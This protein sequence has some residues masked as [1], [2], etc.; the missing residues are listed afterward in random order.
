LRQL[1]ALEE[2]QHDAS[3]AIGGHRTYEP[4]AFRNQVKGHAK[5][6]DS[7]LP[8]AAFCQRTTP[9]LQQSDSAGR[10]QPVRETNVVGTCADREDLCHASQTFEVSRCVRLGC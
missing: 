3:P 2:L 1:A 7:F 4:G 5:A 9:F 10:L 8:P 6:T